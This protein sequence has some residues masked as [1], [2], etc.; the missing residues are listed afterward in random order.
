M[1]LVS[2]CLAGRNVKYNGGNN[3]V[4]W[5]CRWIERHKEQ[6]LLVCPEVMGGLPTPRL[7]AEIQSKGPDP[8]TSPNN[9]RV[10]NKAGE[11][12]TAQF[13][14]G[15]EK[16]LEIANRYHIAA[17]VLKSNSPSCSGS[18]IYDGTFSGTRIAGQGITAALLIEHGVKVYSE[19]TVTPE[20]LEE[21]MGNRCKI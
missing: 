21:L 18:Y 8:G 4:P 20:L 19:K 12:V 9:R 7:P 3:A 11:D 17:A 15:A 2:A 6:V 10:V 14:L 13:L 1:I 16:V 5:L